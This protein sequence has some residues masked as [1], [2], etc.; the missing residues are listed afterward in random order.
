MRSKAG[1]LA[2]VFAAAIGHAAADPQLCAACH[3]PNGNS[4]NAAV[5]SLAAQ[6]AQFIGTQLVMFR[7]KRR[8]DPLMSPVADTLTNADINA[9]GKFFS[10]QAHEPPARKPGDEAMAAGKA[11]AEKFNCVVCHGPALKGQQHIPRLAGQQPEYL[12][13]QLRGFRA[14]TRF[15]MDGNMTSAARPLGDADI[16]VLAN[17]LSALD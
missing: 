14:G 1:L 16:D 3:G 17:Y 9:L 15:D 13:A 6:P 5:P 4:Q 8:T 12:R 7:E 11:L 2:G 10:A